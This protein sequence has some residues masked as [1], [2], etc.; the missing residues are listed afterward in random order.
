MGTFLRKHSKLG[1]YMPVA[2]SLRTAAIT[3]LLFTYHI[4]QDVPQY[5]IVLVQTSYVL[6]IVFGRPHKKLF[7]FVRSLCLE[8]G[9]L[10]NLIV[11]FVDVKILSEYAREDS[12]LFAALAYTEYSI[13][14]LGST[15]S[16][17]SLIYHV[18]KAIKGKKV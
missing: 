17:I 14:G 15:L 6:F 13:Y 10:Y 11:R 7:D 5:F 3:A 16:T 2:L 4:T 8:V 9:L 18:A 1:I 12:T